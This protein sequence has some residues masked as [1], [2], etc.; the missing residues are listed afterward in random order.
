MRIGFVRVSTQDKNL[1]LQT[2]VLESAGCEQIFKDTASG[3]RA[4]RPGLEE[5]L[6]HARGG[7][8]S[9]SGSSIDSDAPSRG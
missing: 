5:A 2:Q 4:K 3:A 8:F 7:M 6:S 9:S 1:D